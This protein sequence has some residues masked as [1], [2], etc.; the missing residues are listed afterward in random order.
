MSLLIRNKELLEKYNKIWDKV[1]NATKE[2]PDN[3]PV[4]KEKYLKTKAKSFKGKMN[5]NFYEDKIP[6]ESSQ[7]NCLSAILIDSVYKTGKNY[8]P[9]VY[10]EEY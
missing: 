8:H 4:Y 7:C 10:L 5:T 6:K 1:S 9:Q 2:R 3:E